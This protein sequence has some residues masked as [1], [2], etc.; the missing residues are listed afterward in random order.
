MDLAGDRLV[1]GVVGAGDHEAAQC[2]EVALDP[3]EP[4][5]VGRQQHELG[6][7]ACEPP[8]DVGGRVRGEVVADDEEPLLG[9]VAATEIAEEAEEVSARA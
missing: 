3:V 5:A 4:G 6:V 2:G 7:V 9:R 1:V 8:L